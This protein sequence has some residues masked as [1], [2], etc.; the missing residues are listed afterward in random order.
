MKGP[1][2]SMIFFSKNN[3]TKRHAQN[4]RKFGAPYFSSARSVVA[5]ET[6]YG[7]KMWNYSR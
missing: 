4:W 7:E 6:V 1:Y 3:Q 2:V 5:K